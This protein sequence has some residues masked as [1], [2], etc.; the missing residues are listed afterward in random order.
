[1]SQYDDEFLED[2]GLLDGL[3]DDADGSRSLDA[4]R[5]RKQE[6]FDEEVQ[7]NIKKLRRSKEFSADER[8]QAALWLGESGDPQAIDILVRVYE[9]DKTPG[10]KQAAEYALGMFRALEQALN[11]DESEQRKALVNIEA[12]TLEG[13]MGRSARGTNRLLSIVMVVLLL[14]FLGIG[15]F[16]LSLPEPS[17]VAAEPTLPVPTLRPTQPVIIDPS[18]VLGALER[19]YTQLDEDARNLQTQ[20]QAIGNPDRQPDCAILFNNPGALSP[21][22]FVREPAYAELQ[23]AVD[24]LNALESRIA[25]ILSQY[26][27]VCDGSITLTTDEA[28][29][30][31]DDI[32]NIQRE[33]NTIPDFLSGINVVPFTPTPTLQATLT[34]TP[35]LTATFTL[36]PTPT[37]DPDIVRT[38]I[39]SVQLILQDMNAL[40]G[41]NS[42]LIT[43]WTD[44]RDA[45]QTQACQD[46]VPILAPN[47]TLP[48]DV[49]QSVPDLA[50]A[51]ENLNLGLDLSRQSWQ[52]FSQWC[53]N[54]LSQ[55]VEIQLQVVQTAKAAFDDAQN[56]LND[57]QTAL[58]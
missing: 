25:Q 1:M 12:I 37:T 29:T 24:R 45:G 3:D 2:D 43:Y 11:G 40:R 28:L 52:A 23:G 6:A 13:R 49:A 16:A 38:H 47:Y 9:K 32:I 14:S 7:A 53:D 58:R 35:T 20:V 56:N 55:P 19:M 33:L 57:A 34:P 39:Q 41:K 10:M 26:R 48:A 22:A 36:T 30:L 42:L 46:E 8:K 15:G 54:S 17:G 4:D 50:R 21:P 5:R 31:G 44:I 51:V 27:G 18:A